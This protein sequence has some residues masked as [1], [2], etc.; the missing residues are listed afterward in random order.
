[1]GKWSI[2]LVDTYMDETQ[3]TA[4]T[5]LFAGR[6]T[7]D[8]DDHLTIG[9]I[10]TDG[11]PEGLRD[12]TL[13]GLDAVWR[14]S[15]FLG[16]KN[17]TVGGWAATSQGEVW[18]GD[19][20]TGDLQQVEVFATWTT[21]SGRLQTGLTTENNFEGDFVQR[22]WQL[23]LIWAF[24]TDLILSSYSQYESTS[25]DIGM[26]NRLRWTIRPGRDLFVV[27]N[28]GWKRPAG[29]R[30]DWSLQPVDDSLIVKLRWTWRW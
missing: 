19:F 12:N 8:V 27:W 22:L 7:Y 24:T 15:T 4:R 14:T 25:G 10:V 3:D 13:V 28:H 29:T 9:T 30:G 20:Y 23:K 6:L 16:D 18:G 26:N 11:D 1:M 21:L 17:F 2:G 5:N